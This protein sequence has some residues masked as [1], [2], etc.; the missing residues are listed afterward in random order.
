MNMSYLFKTLV[1][2]SYFATGNSEIPLWCKEVA[3]LAKIAARYDAM[4]SLNNAKAKATLLTSQQDR[5]DA[6]DEA[7][8][9]FDA[10]LDSLDE[11]YDAR[12]VLCGKLGAARYN[13]EINPTEFLSPKDACK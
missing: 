10:E 8:D 4:A 7:E 3:N 2:L 1:L 9:V 11:V 13:P 12:L 6:V 5:L